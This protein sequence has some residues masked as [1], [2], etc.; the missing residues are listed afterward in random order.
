MLTRTFAPLTAPRSYTEMSLSRADQYAFAG[1]VAV[2][3]THR[4]PCKDTA[5]EDAVGL[6][7]VDAQS[8]VLVIADGLG[9]LPAGELASRLTIE[10]VTRSVSAAQREGVSLRDAILNGIERANAAILATGTGAATTLAAVEI[11]GAQIRSYHVGDSLILVCGQRGKLKFQTVPH[12]PVGYAVEAGLL[13]EAE[14]AH[15]AERNIVSNVVGSPEMRI[16]IG[17][18]LTLASLDTLVLASDGVPDNLYLG[19]LVECVRAGG[20][21]RVARRLIARC[22]SRMQHPQSGTPSHPDDMS[23]IIYRRSDL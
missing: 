1:G 18:T 19:E 14:A 21:R 12:S 6:I 7:P 16:D 10:C 2:A 3:Y 22:E 15:H 5:N 4:S 8:A 11:Q 23:F 9:G 17:P 13:N 20:L